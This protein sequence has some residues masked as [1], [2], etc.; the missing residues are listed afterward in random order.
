MSFFERDKSQSSTSKYIQ[1]NKTTADGG[2]TA[3]AAVLKGTPSD[4]IITPQLKS[5]TNEVITFEA[6]PLAKL[7]GFSAS[8]IPT[9]E[10]TKVEEPKPT[11]NKAEYGKI[12]V[13]ENKAG[14]I[15]INDETPGNVRYINLHPTGTYN[16][17]LDNGDYNIKVTNDRQEITDGNWNI[18]TTKDKIEIVSGNN[19]IEIRKNLTENVKGNFDLNVGGTQNN[20]VGGDVSDDFKSTYTGKIAADYTESVGGNK[21]ETTSGNLEEKISGDH[22]ENVQ[23]SLTITVMG[24]INITACGTTNINSAGS[25][26][27]ASNAPVNIKSSSLVNISAPAIKLG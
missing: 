1:A 20:V 6:N 21:K 25:V 12:Q 5:D 4:K 11:D 9:T 18:T 19:R 17:M 8:L 3:D 10:Q 15:V 24:N 7:L 16:A 26:N 22:K 23:G 2:F 13:K 14:F 27:I